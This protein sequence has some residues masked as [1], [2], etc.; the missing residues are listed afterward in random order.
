MAAVHI[1]N[2]LERPP[3]YRKISYTSMIKFVRDSILIDS[4]SVS[5]LRWTRDDYRGPRDNNEARDAIQEFNKLLEKDGYK[6]F[7]YMPGEDIESN[8][9][10]YYKRDTSNSYPR[11]K[12]VKTVFPG[13][14]YIS[15]G[16]TIET[17]VIIYSD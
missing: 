5:G 11:R 8:R 6:M 15:N 1:K 16:E 7:Y 14:L 13:I 9:I 3:E 2:T 12:V 4:T 17:A 10:T